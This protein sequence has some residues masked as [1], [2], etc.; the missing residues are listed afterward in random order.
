[1]GCLYTWEKNEH[2]LMKRLPVYCFQISVGNDLCARY[3]IIS[4]HKGSDMSQLIHLS[5]FK[6]VTFSLKKIKNKTGGLK[7]TTV[8]LPYLSVALLSAVPAT[9][10]QPQHSGSRACFWHGARRSVIVSQGVTAPKSLTAFPFIT[11]AFHYL[12]P[13]REEGWIQDDKVPNFDYSMFLEFL[14]YD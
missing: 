8:I 12:T 2:Y 4:T 1:M 5:L 11:Q 9:L 7:K 14:S 6:S 10:S 3:L 13:A